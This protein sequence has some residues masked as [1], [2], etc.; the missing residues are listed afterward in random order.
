MKATQL[1]FPEAHN[2]IIF[3]FHKRHSL[4]L[5]INIASD[6]FLP[7]GR[8]LILRGLALKISAI[9]P[10]T[11]ESIDTVFIFICE[12]SA[13][14]SPVATFALDVSERRVYPITNNEITK[15]KG[16]AIA[17]TEDLI[18]HINSNL[19]EY[20]D[21]FIEDVVSRKPL[22]TGDFYV[23]RHVFSDGRTYFGKGKGNRVSTESKR[24]FLYEKAKNDLGNPF[25]EVLCENIAEEDA[26]AIE[27]ELINASRE[28]YG[29]SFVMNITSGPIH[30]T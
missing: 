30:R 2:E 15:R 4:P 22:S 14:K 18:N 6:L 27:A 17:T 12:A 20:Y 9:R 11:T 7:L 23:Y 13:V 26:Y 3:D 5:E 16:D 28:H 21:N 8:D 10:I 25:A 19:D 29:Y 1:K 24:N